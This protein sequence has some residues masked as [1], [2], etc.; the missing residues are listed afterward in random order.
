MLK[1]NN[2]SINYGKK[3]VLNGCSFACELG[4][5]Y[6]L[7]GLNGSGKTSL[8]NSLYGFVPKAA[9]EFVY[10]NRT[11]QRN[12]IAYLETQNY[13]YSNITGEE[14]L[15][16]FPKHNQELVQEYL[17][18]FQLPLHQIIDGYSTGMKKKLAIIGFLH[19]DKP[20]LILDEPFNGLDMEANHYLEKLILQLK[21]QHKIIIITSHILGTLFPICDEIMWLNGG[22]IE[23]NFTKNEFETIE[24]ILFE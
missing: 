22:K 7:I 20:I 13:Y 9:G 3:Q 1:V 24:K 17:G 8:I 11:L 12:D 6:G 21:N 5:V 16:L 19:F 10:D 2:L 18:Y 23:K 15:S 4:Y 14:Y